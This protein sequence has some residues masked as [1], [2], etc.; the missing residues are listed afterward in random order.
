MNIYSEIQS[1]VPLAAAKKQEEEIKLV[2]SKLELSVG[3]V[4]LEEVPYLKE[5][6][7]KD[8]IDHQKRKKL[9]CAKNN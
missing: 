4:M 1:S 6:E 5:G 7:Y 2:L 3:K 8:L 9:K